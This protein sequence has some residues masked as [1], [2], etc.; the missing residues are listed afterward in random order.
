[1]SATTIAKHYARITRTWPK[2]ALRPT[3]QFQ[4]ALQQRAANPL[5]KSDDDLRD[6]NALY[7]LL[8][9]RYAKRYPANPAVFKPASNP[10]Y[11]DD[12]IAELSQAPSRSWFQRWLNSW[13]GSLRLQ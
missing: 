3:V 1:M 8:G 11:Y 13:K 9:D 2:D 4:A 5:P 6:I 10:A 12:L 7:S